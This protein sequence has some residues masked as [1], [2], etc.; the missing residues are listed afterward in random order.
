MIKAIFFDV[1]GTTVL[2]RDRELI[3]SCFLDAFTKHGVTISKEIIRN[4]RGYD[5]KEAVTL[6]LKESKNDL[7]KE[8]LIYSTF[9]ESVSQSIDNFYEHAQFNEVMTELRKKNIVVGIGTGL[10]QGI[11]GS[12]FTALDW[13]KYQFEYI[14]TSDQI[15]KGRPHP[16]MIFDMMTSLNLR[17]EEFLKVGDTVADI[18]EG[19]NAKVFTAA[20]N[21]G[22]QSEELLRAENPDYLLG[23]LSSVIS[24]V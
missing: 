23:S 11:F 15:G 4:F 8:E 24:I 22:T 17:V 13:S 14:G 18:R 12:I 19:K 20:L 3:N 16:D 7:K 1:I 9:V 6:I 2:E 5:K 10:P 21:S